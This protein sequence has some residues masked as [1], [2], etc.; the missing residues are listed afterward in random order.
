MNLKKAFEEVSVIHQENS[1]VC[2][3]KVSDDSV[4]VSSEIPRSTQENNIVD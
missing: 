2:G 4:Y 3:W 1:S